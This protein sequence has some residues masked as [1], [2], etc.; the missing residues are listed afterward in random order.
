MAGIDESDVK[1]Q[2][3]KWGMDPSEPQQVEAAYG[4]YHHVLTSTYYSK[5]LMVPWVMNNVQGMLLAVSTAESTR[6][7]GRGVSQNER[8]Q[9]I[10]EP[11]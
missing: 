1:Y 9:Y 4:W 7:F 5:A 2:M 11:D 6:A 8:G 3:Q 10:V